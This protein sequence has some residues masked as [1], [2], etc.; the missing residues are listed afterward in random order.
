MIRFELTETQEAE[1]KE[2]KEAIKKVYGNYGTYEFR[3]SHAS[4]IGLS[5]VV[6][7]DLA[8]TELDLTEIETW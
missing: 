4:G 8:Q 7:S 1:L 3:F 2:W 5:V 6:Y